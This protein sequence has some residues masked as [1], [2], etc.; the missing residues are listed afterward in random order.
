MARP[1]VPAVLIRIIT[2]RVSI[3]CPHARSLWVPGTST[4]YRLLTPLIFSA[5]IAL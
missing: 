5:I 3:E 4:E 1:F 2:R